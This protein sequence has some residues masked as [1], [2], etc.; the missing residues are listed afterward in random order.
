M[1]RFNNIIFGMM[2]KFFMWWFEK[3]QKVYFRRLKMSKD[4]TINIDRI[5][6]TRI[7]GNMLTV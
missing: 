7:Q 2:I 6:Q 4:T 1:V 3:N 5:E